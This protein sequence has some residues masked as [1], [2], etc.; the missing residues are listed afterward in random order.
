LETDD[1]LFIVLWD[2]SEAQGKSLLAFLQTPMRGMAWLKAK[3][4]LGM[5]LIFIPVLFLH[6]ISVFS[7]RQVHPAGSCRVGTPVFGMDLFVF[8]RSIHFFM[9]YR[10]LKKRWLM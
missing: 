8:C 7:F 5:I 2:P 4:F 9:A 1:M 10:L 3:L 6:L